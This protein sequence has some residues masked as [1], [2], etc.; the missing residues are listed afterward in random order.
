MSL[1]NVANIAEIVSML[2]VLGSVIFGLKQLQHFRLQR[3]TQAAMELTRYFY[4]P[5]FVYALNRLLTLSEEEYRNNLRH[6][7]IE[8]E[9]SAML[10]SLTFESIAIM[11]HRRMLLIDDVWELMGGIL[12]NVWIKLH[13]WVLEKREQQDSETYNEWAEWLVNQFEKYASDEQCIPANIKYRD[14]KP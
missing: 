9:N 1:N 4:N 14:W 8:Y 7:G 5:E 3:K 11:V 6:K 12:T 10:V 2:V 13:P